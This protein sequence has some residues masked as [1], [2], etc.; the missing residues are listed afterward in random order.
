MLPK[1]FWI[2]LVRV[3]PEILNVGVASIILTIE[4][5]LGVEYTNPELLDK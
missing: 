3:L 4:P 1:L 5:E 2:I